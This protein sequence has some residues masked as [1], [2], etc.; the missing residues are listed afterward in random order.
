VTEDSPER[1]L[2]DLQRAAGVLGAYC[3]VERS[4]FELTGAMAVE[5]GTEPAVAVRL[6]ALSGEHAWHAEL[7]A[8]RLPVLSGVDAQA[9][10]VLPDPLTWVF[11]ELRSG[12]PVGRLAGLFRVV[13]P[14]LVTSYQRH[15]RAASTVA[16]TP[17]RRALRLVL[18]DEIEA[19]A[20]GEALVEGLLR[21]PGD[22]SAAAQAQLALETGLVEAGLGAGLVPWPGQRA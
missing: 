10:V 5:G 17:T 4:L 13:L 15:L 8:D 21:G 7:W 12:G 11:A 9:L 3:A 19:W 6:D 20:G 16:E 2:L 14:R 18:R 22:V 1:A